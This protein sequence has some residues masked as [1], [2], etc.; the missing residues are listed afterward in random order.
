MFKMRKKDS[1]LDSIEAYACA[2]LMAI[3]C[4]CSCS[5][6]CVCETQT[7]AQV[8]YSGAH[9]SIQQVTYGQTYTGDPSVYGQQY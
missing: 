7:M 1:A 3:T 5:C 8:G 4:T 2:C 6:G 9:S